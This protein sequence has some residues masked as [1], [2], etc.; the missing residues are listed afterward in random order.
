MVP[1]SFLI[2]I[3]IFEIKKLWSWTG[4]VK[5]INSVSVL[6]CLDDDWCLVFCSYGPALL[7]MHPQIALDK[8]GSR[9]RFYALTRW[10]YKLSNRHHDSSARVIIHQFVHLV[11]FVHIMCVWLCVLLREIIC[12]S[13][14]YALNYPCIYCLNANFRRVVPHVLSCI[15]HLNLRSHVNFKGIIQEITLLNQYSWIFLFVI[16]LWN[17]VKLF[18]S[19]QVELPFN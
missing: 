11:W 4:H 17:S 16:Q 9:F 1:G 15:L 5:Y 10:S 19:N 12:T 14:K 3:F 13:I 18:Y 7:G 6:T 2:I 8:P